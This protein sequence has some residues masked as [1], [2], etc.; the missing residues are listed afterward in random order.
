MQPQCQRQTSIAANLALPEQQHCKPGH[1]ADSTR[2]LDMALRKSPHGQ[3]SHQRQR[4]LAQSTT[5]A[6]MQNQ[7]RAD[8]P[9]S[10]GNCLETKQWPTGSRG[11]GPNLLFTHRVGVARKNKGNHS[12]RRR[13]W[14]PGKTRETSRLQIRVNLHRGRITPSFLLFRLVQWPTNQEIRLQTTT[15]HSA[16][17]ASTVARPPFNYFSIFLSSAVSIWPQT[18]TR[19]LSRPV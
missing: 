6:S 18:T 5:T 11:P 3:K 2:C 8:R 16:W 12:T 13:T 4:Q 17:L 15:M 7:L 9:T 1:G 10:P 14:N 19:R